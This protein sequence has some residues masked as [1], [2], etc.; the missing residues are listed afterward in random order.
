MLPG[1]L[2]ISD[3]YLIVAQK[4]LK[5]IWFRPVCWNKVFDTVIER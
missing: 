5:L 1:F 2:I 3:K 4:G